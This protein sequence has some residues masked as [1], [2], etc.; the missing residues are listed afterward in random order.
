MKFNEMFVT[1]SLLGLI[2]FGTLT[3]M[4]SLQ[5]Q[6]GLTENI[7]DDSVINKTYT[8]LSSKLIQSSDTANTTK[9]AFEKDIPEP[10][11]FALVIFATIG[12]VQTITGMVLGVYNILIVL[13]ATKLGIPQV[14][15]NVIG[16]LVIVSLVLGAW[17]LYRAGD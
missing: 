2:I 16:S 10:S 4:V 12:V 11:T 1:F 14:V 9:T 15:I 3:F 6:N 5:T 13:P 7:L 17:R 8:N